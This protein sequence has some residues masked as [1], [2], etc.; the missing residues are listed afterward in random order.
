MPGQGI[1]EER[2]SREE[3]GA[4]LLPCTAAPQP[5]TV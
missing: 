2:A 3:R 4:A 1:G 5:H